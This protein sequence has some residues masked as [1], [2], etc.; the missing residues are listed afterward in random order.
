MSV[1][2]GV[3]RADGPVPGCG[4]AAV[5]DGG[6]AIVDQRRDRGA[7]HRRSEGRPIVLG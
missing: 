6:A 7:A 4:A 3:F 5:G 1:L 2:A